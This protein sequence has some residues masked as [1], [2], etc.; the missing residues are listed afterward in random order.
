LSF[1][2]KDFLENKLDVNSMIFSKH[3]LDDEFLNSKN[4]SYVGQYPFMLRE[5]VPDF[6]KAPNYDDLEILSVEDYPMVIEDYIKIFSEARGM[7]KSVVKGFFD[8]QK[9][10][11][12]NHFFVAYLSDNP[13]GIFYAISYEENAFVMEVSIKDQYKNS[14]ILTAM[15]KAAKESALKK[16]ILNFYSIPTSEFSVKVMTEQGYKVIGSYHVWRK[17]NDIII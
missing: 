5:E 17:F 11:N 8:I 2:D 10:K 14:G 12:N 7:E 4:I 16:D 9:L 3:Y 13:A 1:S 15:A 6:Y